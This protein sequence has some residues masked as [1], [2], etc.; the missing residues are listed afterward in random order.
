MFVRGTEISDYLF[1]NF[2]NLHG[3]P[4]KEIKNASTKIYHELL[5]RTADTHER[6]QDKCETSLQ[7]IMANDRVRK[8]GKVQE[9]L[10]QPLQVLYG[11]LLSWVLIVI[12]A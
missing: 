8:T 3:S 5:Q 7:N 1:G 6:V 11:I 4:E 10:I 2:L 9:I 12:A